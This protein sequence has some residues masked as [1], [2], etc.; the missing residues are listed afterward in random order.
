MSKNMN[1]SVKAMLF[2]IKLNK[3]A[4]RSVPKI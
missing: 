1:F 2:F 3:F 4:V